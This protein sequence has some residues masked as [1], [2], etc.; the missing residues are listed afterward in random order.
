VS[1]ILR[2]EEEIQQLHFGV[3]VPMANKF[4]IVEVFEEGDFKCR[5]FHPLIVVVFCCATQKILAKANTAA[6][7]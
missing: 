3:S 6:H 7:I 4:L 2:L 5:I 1:I